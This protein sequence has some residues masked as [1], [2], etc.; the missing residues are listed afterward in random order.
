VG[1]VLD[2]RTDA[3]RAVR[4]AFYDVEGNCLGRRG[5]CARQTL[6]SIVSAALYLI[7]GLLG[8]R[9]LVAWAC[10]FLALLRGLYPLLFRLFLPGLLDGGLLRLCSFALPHSPLALLSRLEAPFL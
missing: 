9:L 5:G 2:L 1:G 8:R 10:C 6:S 7:L 3:A 4:G